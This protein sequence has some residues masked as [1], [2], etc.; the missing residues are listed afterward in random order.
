MSPRVLVAAELQNLLDP[1][2]LA[3]LE[4]TWLAADEPTPRGDFVALVPL[5]SRWVG[6]TELKNLPQLRIVA[7]VAVGYNN[8]DIVAAE[9]RKVTV[10]NTPG[11]LTDA[12][13]DLTWA[14]ILATARRVVDGVDLVRSGTW[15]GWHPEQLLG[16][17]L[18]GRTLGLLGAGRIGQ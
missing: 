2:E 16:L 3:G 8:I 13:A 5:L 14:L 17:E 1:A 10:T 18:R 4:V 7:N 15:T 12:T 6:G 11:V 9:M